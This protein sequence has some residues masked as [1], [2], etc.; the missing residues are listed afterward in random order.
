MFNRENYISHLGWLE[1]EPFLNRIVAS[2]EKWILY[3]NIKRREQRIDKNE[4][5]L[6][7]PKQSPHP[8]KVMRQ[9][10]GI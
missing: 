2:D 1:N 7:Q 8:N 4:T 6:F 9:L 5:P 3:N 10:G